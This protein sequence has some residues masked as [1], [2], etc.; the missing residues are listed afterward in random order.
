MINISNFNLIDQQV[1]GYIFSWHTPVLNS[2]FSVTTEVGSTALVS[3][4]TLFFIMWL[5][6]KKRYRDMYLS[7]LVV[8]GST[9]TTYYLKMFFVRPRPEWAPYHVDTFSF[10]SGHATGAFALYAV[11]AFVAL[12]HVNNKIHRNGILIIAFSLIGLV[13]FSRVYLGFHY[14]TDVLAGYAVACVWLVFT[15]FLLG[16]KG[17]T[18]TTSLDKK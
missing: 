6:S 11:I 4:I 18:K 1:L 13:G 16:D 17:H 9:L 3:I 7:V 5:Y 12:K 14:L 10:P 2:F 15:T 8:V